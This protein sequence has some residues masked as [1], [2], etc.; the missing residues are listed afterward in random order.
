MP[1]ED[2][3]F[4]N[5][6][7]ISNGCRLDFDISTNNFSIINYDSPYNWVSKKKYDFFKSLKE[8]QVVDYLEKALVKQLKLMIPK[9]NFGCI[10]SGGIDSTLQ[11]RLIS[12]ISEPK[13]NLTINHIGKDKIIN[14]ISNFNSYLSP[15]ISVKNLSKKQYVQN[16]LKSYRITSSPL[17]THDLGG[18]L[19]IA[20]IFKKRKCKV[21]FSADGCDELFG[22]QQLYYKLF[23]KLKKYKHNISPYSSMKNFNFSNRDKFLYKYSNQLKKYWLKINKKYNFL[24][25][26]EKNIQSSLFLDYFIQSINVANR[27]NDLISCN[28]SIEPRNV[29][30]QKSILKI[31]INL[32]LKYKI[33]FKFP[34]KILKQ[35]FLLKKIFTKNLNKKLIF[36][37]EGFSGFPSSLYKYLTNKSYLRMEK[38]L[39]RDIIINKY[40]YYDKKNYKR[41][42]NW[43][44]IN[45]NL[46]L[47]K[48]L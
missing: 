13:I 43:K 15:A 17:H 39:G 14:S 11:A 42:L 44:L 48:F 32:P 25:L 3:S 12:C 7:L 9:V 31:I 1:L 45:V 37:K 18:R 38:F 33:N 2:T 4:K 21:F 28:Y 40:N 26:K 19:E 47:N 5:I 29:Y 24:G 41:D 46:F 6:K 8:K 30:I 22:G 36:K 34:D 20:K 16:I 10:A 27:S 23:S 35:K